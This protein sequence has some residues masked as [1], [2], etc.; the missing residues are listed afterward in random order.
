[1]K[2]KSRVDTIYSRPLKF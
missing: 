1:M 2:L